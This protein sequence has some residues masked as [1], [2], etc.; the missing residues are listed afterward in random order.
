MKCKNLKSHHLIMYGATQHDVLTSGQQERVPSSGQS[1]PA[2]TSPADWVW[3]MDSSW[4]GNTFSLGS[5]PVT[6]C[7]EVP[8][9]LI[10]SLV[11]TSAAAWLHLVTW[12]LESVATWVSYLV[13]HFTCS[14]PLNDPIMCNNWLEAAGLP[15]VVS[16]PPQL[17]LHFSNLTALAT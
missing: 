11:Y 14:A 15:N 6:S 1:Q 5:Y 12:Q 4:T 13:L 2:I 9:T 10:G 16:L 8:C 17:W 7:W 3:G